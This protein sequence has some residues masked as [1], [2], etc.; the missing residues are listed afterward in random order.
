MPPGF[1]KN[2]EGAERIRL[3]KVAELS[4]HPLNEKLY[5]NASS[6]AELKSS[7]KKWGILEPILVDRQSQILSGHRRWTVAKELDHQEIPAFLFDGTQLEGEAILIEANR[8]RVK[9]K[10]QIAR[11]TAELVRIEKA[12]AAERRKRKAI[13][14]VPSER[15]SDAGR[16][17]E[18]V[19][20]ATGQSKMTVLKQ[21]AIVAAANQRNKIALAGL[22]D[23]DNNQGS[24]SAI[25]RELVQPTPILVPKSPTRIL[26]EGY[27]AR[28]ES[29]GLIANV[30]AVSSGSTTKFDLRLSGL[31]VAQ[32]DSLIEV[33][34]LKERQA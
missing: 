4:A 22:Q 5:G 20:K 32:L 3:R 30:S 8:Q 25:Y 33:L 24:V 10:G 7:V 28:F 21:T 14:D 13:S 29:L 34:A 6:D 1:N 2:G 19:G 15:P 23:L 12:L 31:S 18:K 27:E 17:I 16:T 26:R 11:E 9:T